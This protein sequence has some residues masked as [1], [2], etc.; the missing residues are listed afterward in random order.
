MIIS[1]KES[2][3]NTQKQNNTNNHDK[4]MHTTL[5]TN[6]NWKEFTKTLHKFLQLLKKNKD[7]INTK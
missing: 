7:L 2:L 1:K 3:Q 6:Y 5:P 4:T